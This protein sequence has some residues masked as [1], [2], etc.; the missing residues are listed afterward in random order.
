MTGSHHAGPPSHPRSQWAPW[1]LY[2]GVLLGAN[3]LRAFLMSGADLP[4]VAVI[5]VALGQAAVL[6]V[7][8]TAIWRIA[9]RETL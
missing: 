5:A 4:T 3:Y 2:V 7:V 6:A 1:W 8:I 9:R